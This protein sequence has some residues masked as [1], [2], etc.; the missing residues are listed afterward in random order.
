MYLFSLDRQEILEV[1]E[2]SRV[3]RGDHGELI[4]Y[5]RPEVRQHV[6][7]ITDY[8]NGDDVLFPNPIIIALPST[9]KWTSSRGPN[10]S[11]GIATS[12]MIEIPLAQEQSLAGS[13]TG[14]NGHSPCHGPGVRTSRFQSTPSSPTRLT[15]N[16]I[17]S[18]GSTTRSHYREGWSPNCCRTS[19]LHCRRDSP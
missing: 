2:I 11:D 17:S 6:K 19:A 7:E 16:A 9:V 14:S 4:G 15:F 3:G 18:C 13:S 10:V 12:G 8:L 5:Q 1:A